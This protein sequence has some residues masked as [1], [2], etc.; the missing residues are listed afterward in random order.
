MIFG[1]F[2]FKNILVLELLLEWIRTFGDVG[3]ERL[4][5]AHGTDMSFGVPEGSRLYWVE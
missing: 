1:L 4:H 5:F 2:G 3:T